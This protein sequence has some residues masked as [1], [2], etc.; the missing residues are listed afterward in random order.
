MERETTTFTC[1]QCRRRSTA[2]ADEYGD[3][4]CS[5]G[6]DPDNDENE[7]EDDE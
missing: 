7:T 6:W 3:H 1:P 5:C 4:G 2:L